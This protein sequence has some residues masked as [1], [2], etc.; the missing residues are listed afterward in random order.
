MISNNCVYRKGPLGCWYYEK[1][2]VE[3]GCQDKTT[4]E[5]ARSRA[6]AEQERTETK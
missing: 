6:Q 5:E 1:L 3:Q 2:C 4:H